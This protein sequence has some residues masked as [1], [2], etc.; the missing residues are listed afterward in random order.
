MLVLAYAVIPVFVAVVTRDAEN[1]SAFN[2]AF[3]A[4]MILTVMFTT[5]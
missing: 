1:L 5:W 2:D 3:V 4:S